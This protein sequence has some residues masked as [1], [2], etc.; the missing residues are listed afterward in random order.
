MIMMDDNDH[1]RH[2]YCYQIPCLVQD[3]LVMAEK[4]WYKETSY[5]KKKW[6][7][8][9]DICTCNEIAHSIKNIIYKQF[10]P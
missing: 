4:L 10:S 5:I 1:H 6:N 9:L 3:S 7:E 8:Q 2:H